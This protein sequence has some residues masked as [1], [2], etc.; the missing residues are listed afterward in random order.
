[1]SFYAHKNDQF[2]Q[3]VHEHGASNECACASMVYFQWLY[4]IMWNA[5]V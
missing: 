5:Q 4:S 1:M 3:L 2:H